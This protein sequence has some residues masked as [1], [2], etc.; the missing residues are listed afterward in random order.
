MKINRDNYEAYFLDYHEGQLS[1]GM[2]EEVL[3]FVENNPD[4][5]SIFHEFESISL[6][7]ETDIV[8]ENKSSL[9]KT[10]VFASQKINELNYEDIMI[11][12]VEGLLDA[13]QI[14]LLEE[15]VSIN[16]QFEKDRKLFALTRLPK[17]DN[18]TFE[19]KE[20]L[21]QKAIPVGAINA[22][23]DNIKNS[24]NTTISN[25]AKTPENNQVAT[26][27]PSEP[28]KPIIEP[29]TNLASNK[30]SFINHI[31]TP[32]DANKGILAASVRTSVESLQSKPVV[33][34]TNNW[35]VDPQFT[36]IR[37]SQMYMNQ[38]ME[39]YYNIKLSEQM[40][41]AQLNEK[42]ATPGKT[43][44][45]A[46]VDKIG[47]LFAFNKPKPELEDKK[48]VNG[49]TFAQLGV[50]T[51]NAVTS[52]SVAL[53]IKKDDEGKVVGYGLQSKAVDIEKYWEK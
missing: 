29:G 6:D 10:Q 27:N 50:Q 33:A 17:E 35:Y 36:F 14:T 24:I 1:L 31:I 3:L 43:I 40:E 45:N 13:E 8:F 48:S 38:N 37:T 23:K 7:A 11:C 12:E 47:N 46:A 2:A 32:K 4:L 25:P 28:V 41:Y 30:T 52:S 20:N 5:Q 49:W 39:L 51:F 9:K 44:L 18:I 15:F 26:N 42:D 16:S 34:I 22:E 19:G 53:D 21:K